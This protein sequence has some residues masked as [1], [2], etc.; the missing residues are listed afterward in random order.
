[1]GQTPSIVDIPDE[2]GEILSSLS[3]DD[4]VRSSRKRVFHDKGTDTMYLDGRV[5][6]LDERTVDLGVAILGAYAHLKGKRFKLVP[7]RMVS[8]GIRVGHLSENV[9]SKVLSRLED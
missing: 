4:I 9:V 5:F 7:G 2:W 8:Q 6:D 3:I 1:M